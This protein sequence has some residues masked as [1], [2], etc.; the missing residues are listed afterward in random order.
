MKLHFQNCKQLEAWETM[1]TTSLL[2]TADMNQNESAKGDRGKGPKCSPG[3]MLIHLYL[4]DFISRVKTVEGDDES[5]YCHGNL[6]IPLIWR[7]VMSDY[8]HVNLISK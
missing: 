3:Q 1:V 5:V 7:G 6:I 4:I 2:E 8:A